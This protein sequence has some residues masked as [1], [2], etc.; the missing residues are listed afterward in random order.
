LRPASF[1]VSSPTTRRRGGVYYY[2]HPIDNLSVS[3]GSRIKRINVGDVTIATKRSMLHMLLHHDSW[4]ELPSEWRSKGGLDSSMFAITRTKGLA[5]VAADAAE[6]RCREALWVLAGTMLFFS[7]RSE[8]RQFGL[9]GDAHK[10]TSEVSLFSLLDTRVHQR[11]SHGG[12]IV[13]VQLESRWWKYFR[14]RRLKRFLGFANDS[15]LSSHWKQTLWR[16]ASLAGKSY[17]AQSRSEAFLYQ[18]FALDSLMLIRP[19]CYA[20]KTP[21]RPSIR[22][23]FSGRDRTYLFGQM[24]NRA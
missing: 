10:T 23:L 17:M 16:A 18:M 15:K 8:T 7:P 2:V 14:E 24:R 6:Q 9:R 21:I 1:S 19:S 11:W 13:P 22:V 3:P 4:K 20:Y 5:D 12:T